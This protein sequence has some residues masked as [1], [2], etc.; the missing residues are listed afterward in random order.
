MIQTGGQRFFLLPLPRRSG[1]SSDS[2][3]AL[4]RAAM[5]SATAGRWRRTPL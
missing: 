3:A 1:G 4:A 2:G 5:S